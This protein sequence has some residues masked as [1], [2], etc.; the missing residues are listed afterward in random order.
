MQFTD[1]Q[2]QGLCITSPTAAVALVTRC[3]SLRVYWSYVTRP[4]E[5]VSSSSSGERCCKDVDLAVA[6]AKIS[7]DAQTRT[8]L[9]VTRRFPAPKCGANVTFTTHFPRIFPQV[10]F[11]KHMPVAYVSWASYSTHIPLAYVLTSPAPCALDK[12]AS[13]AHDIRPR[14]RPTARLPT[15]KTSTDAS[16]GLQIGRAHV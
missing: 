14:L 12:T 11:S 4:V 10:V 2:T 8:S 13:G 15:L 7:T 3:T 5:L 6:R 9:R 16:P 1:G